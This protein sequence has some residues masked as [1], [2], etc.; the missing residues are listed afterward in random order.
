MVSG[1]DI[2]CS[3]DLCKLDRAWGADLVDVFDEPT[4]F[5]GALFHACDWKPNLGSVV[6]LTYSS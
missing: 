3:W 5:S 1:R 2:V 4:Y 6:T